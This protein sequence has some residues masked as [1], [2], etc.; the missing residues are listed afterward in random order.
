MKSPAKLITT[1][2]L[3]GALLAGLTACASDPNT[4][5][6]PAPPTD[7]ETTVAP[8]E[9]ESFRGTFVRA[10]DGSTIE[11]QPVSFENGQP[12][13]EPNR[14]VRILGMQAPEAPEC[15]AESAMEYFLHLFRPD[16][17]LVMDMEPALKDHTDEDGNTI[18]Y[19]TRGAGVTESI[20][21]RMVQSGFAYAWYPEGEEPPASF[22]D[23]E[24]HEATER[25]NRGGIWFEECD[26]NA[27]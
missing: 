15:G 19:V 9:P 1:A 7:I 27:G 21:V 26:P 23:Y 16:E 3:A 17:Y 6:A 10:L 4:E 13:G 25:A 5:A 24:I 12:T 8:E 20:G 22:E 14:T 11:V 18:A 2:A